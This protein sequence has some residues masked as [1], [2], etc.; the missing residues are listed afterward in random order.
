[1]GLTTLTVEI[2]NPAR[3][4]VTRKVKF[5]VDSGAVFS[6]VPSAVLRELRIRP[7]VA[8]EFHLA[9]GSEITRKKGIALFRYGKR[10]GGA[11]VVFGEEGD[12]TLLGATTLE[13]LGLALDPIKRV[14]KPL[15]MILAR[16]G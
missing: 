15:P 2:G 3:P 7:L 11:D 4:N 13:S 5:L 9:D 1:M 12:S 6:V 16:E 14:L 10:V 8:E